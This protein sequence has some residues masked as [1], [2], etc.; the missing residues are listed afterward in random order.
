VG[1]AFAQLRRAGRAREVG[2]DRSVDV[3]NGPRRAPQRRPGQPRWTV[4]RPSGHD[5]LA[6][7][8]RAFSSLRSAAQEARRLRSSEVGAERIVTDAG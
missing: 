4:R 7:S 8:P 6:G 1:R 5:R 2:N 3:S